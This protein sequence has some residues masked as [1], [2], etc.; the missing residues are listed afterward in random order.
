MTNIVHLTH[1]LAIEIL[2]LQLHLILIFYDHLNEISITQSKL[3]GLSTLENLLSIKIHSSWI[4]NTSV[5]TF[6]SIISSQKSFYQ[7]T[8]NYF[9]IYHDSSN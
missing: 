9:P 5:F 8:Y 4:T 2:S 1:L 3:I 6:T 7:I